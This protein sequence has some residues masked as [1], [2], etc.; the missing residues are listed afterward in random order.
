M[1]AKAAIRLVPWGVAGAMLGRLVWERLALGFWA[2]WLVPLAWGATTSV[3]EA[4]ALMAG[5]YGGALTGSVVALALF[6]GRM[7]GPARLDGLHGIAGR[8]LGG[9]A[10]R[11]CRIPVSTSWCATSLPRGFGPGQPAAARG[12]GNGLAVGGGYGELS[13]FGPLGSRIDAS[14]K[15]PPGVSG[16]TITGVGN[17]DARRRA[18]RV[19]PVRA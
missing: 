9:G 14:G 1:R 13:R 15:R 6:R 19:A 2:L 10:G 12:A 11:A 16:R 3:A 5:Y 17:L 4:G 8:A 18:P 7:G